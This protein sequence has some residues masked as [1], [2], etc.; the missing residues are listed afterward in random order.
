MARVYYLIRVYPSIDDPAEEVVEDMSQPFSVQHA[1]KS[2]HKNGVLQWT[3]FLSLINKNLR[4]SPKE[5]NIFQQI[6]VN[7]KHFL[8]FYLGVEALRRA[9]NVVRIPDDPGNDL[10]L[11]GPHSP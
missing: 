9:A 5:Q 11:L 2:S 4:K 1:V 10:N 8:N 3:A 7:K 6:L